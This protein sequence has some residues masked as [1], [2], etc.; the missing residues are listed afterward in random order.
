MSI[1]ETSGVVVVVVTIS[2]FVVVV[3]AINP[4]FKVDADHSRAVF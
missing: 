2:L 4:C 1:G 3:V